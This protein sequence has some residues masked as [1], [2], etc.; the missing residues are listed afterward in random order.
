[1]QIKKLINES[2]RNKKLQ[3]ENLITW[4]DN[5]PPTPIDKKRKK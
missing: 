5:L 1:M 3:P 4:Y 2:Y